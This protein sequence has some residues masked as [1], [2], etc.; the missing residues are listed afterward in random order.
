MNDTRKQIIELIEPY[1]DKSLSE[2]CLIEI[3]KPKLL[4]KN[5]KIKELN[6]L[7]WHCLSEKQIDILKEENR[8]EE[9]DYRLIKL[10]KEDFEIEKWS[11][12]PAVYD[13]YNCIRHYVR[14][15]PNWKHIFNNECLKQELY[16]DEYLG[17]KHKWKE[18]KDI[19]FFHK[20][21]ILEKIIWHYDITAV[22]KY[23][24]SLES[25]W[26]LIENWNIELFLEQSP[27]WEI[28]NKPLH[29]YTE[30]EEK[31]LL[32]LLLKLK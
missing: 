7:Y 32:D 3:Q 23:V 4:L 24:N 5:N 9:E 6:K 29:L 17:E 27:I 16:I 10:N 20:Y 12:I 30:Q 18:F 13:H 22:L 26:V 31:E 19:Y 8:Y 25:Y 14:N 15:I 21:Y 28:L 1:M 2:G 11:I